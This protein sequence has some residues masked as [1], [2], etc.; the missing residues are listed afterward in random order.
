MKFRNSDALGWKDIQVVK[1]MKG[2]SF[3]NNLETF[4]NGDLIKTAVKA[5]NRITV[6][7]RHKQV[8]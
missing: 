7:T 6:D 1:A 5:K 4:V 3:K 8:A 2:K